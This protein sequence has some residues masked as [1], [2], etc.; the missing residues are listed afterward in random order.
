MNGLGS[1]PAP[2]LRLLGDIPSSPLDMAWLT[3]MAGLLTVTVPVQA[4]LAGS[5]FS[6]AASVALLLLLAVH[7]RFVLGTLA[8]RPGG[9]WLVGV[10][11]WLTFVPLALFGAAWTP[12]CGLLAG[13]LLVVAGRIRSA[14]LVALAVCCGPVL[15]A[16]P[17]EGL[18]DRGWALA[19]PVLGL[20]EYAL[21]SLAARAQ[22]LA[23]A[24]TDAIRTTVALERRRFSRDLHDLVGHR[25]TALV[26][27]TQLIDRLVDEENEKAKLEVGETLELLRTLAGDVRAVAHGG[28]RSSLEVEM[29]S[30][31]ALLESVG[32][33][34]QIRVACPDLPGDVADALTHAL[35][36]GVTN[37]LRHAEARQCA[38]Q[39]LERDELVRLSIK[40]DGV[41]PVRRTGESGQGL[42]NLTERMADVGGWL[43]ITAVRTGQFTFS[44]YVPQIN[45]RVKFTNGYEVST[46][47]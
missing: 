23:S 6:S 7:A 32:V 39:L 44:V 46:P 41:H 2:R 1:E 24:R 33:R 9:W 22:W 34:C 8:G 29:S 37:V 20:M 42:M 27:K 47:R 17:H 43:E 18:A 25:L 26:L 10:Q 16:A 4:E 36:E 19:A 30:A 12:M 15:L 28:R 5:G 31:R 11:A 38:I 35:R 40:N 14:T 45:K 21:V 13:A 3:L